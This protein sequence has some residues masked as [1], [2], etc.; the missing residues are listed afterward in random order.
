MEPLQ[1]V[2]T[3][4]SAVK[5]VNI[6]LWL[7][8]SLESRSKVASPFPDSQAAGLEDRDLNGIS[9]F[10]LKA[11]EQFWPR[12]FPKTKQLNAL[13]LYITVRTY[14]RRRYSYLSTSCDWIFVLTLQVINCSF[15]PLTISVAFPFPLNP[16]I[17]LLRACLTSEPSHWTFA[18]L[19]QGIPYTVHKT[20]L[21]IALGC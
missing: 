4:E 9:H 16:I 12:W 18:I 17:L 19:S 20:S 2:Q 7:D 10:A 15:P 13:R 11:A 8:S 21:A 14:C 3:P 5:I 1:L 6:Y